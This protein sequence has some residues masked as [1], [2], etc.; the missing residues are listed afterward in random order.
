MLAGKTVER[1]RGEV[2]TTRRYTNPSPLPLPLSLTIPPMMSS[3]IILI[4]NSH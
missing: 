4:Q 2:L 1:L 3:L